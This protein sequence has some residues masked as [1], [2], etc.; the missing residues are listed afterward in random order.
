V[1]VIVCSKCGTRNEATA[2]F[3][4]GCGSFLEYTGTKVDDGAPGPAGPVVTP[5][6]AVAVPTPAPVEPPAVSPLAAVAEPPAV[7]PGVPLPSA[8]TGAPDEQPL[9][10]RPTDEVPRP[11]RPATPVTPPPV[12]VAK[13]GDIIC[14]NCHTPNEPSRHFCRACGKPLVAAAPVAKV[15]WW[16]RLFERKPAAA[17][18]AGT[19]PEGQ[20]ETRRSSGAFGA[21]LRNIVAL[22]FTVLVTFGLAG[23]IAV[24]SVHSL[25][26]TGIRDFMRNFSSPV[27]VFPT[28]A[29]G[30]Q[31]A[32][33]GP[34]L[35]QDGSHNQY[36]AG[37]TS[38]TLPKLQ[39]T[40]NKPTD[41]VLVIIT[42][43]AEDALNDFA[44][45]KE[46]VFTFSDGTVLETPLVEASL[47]DD[48][49]GRGP[50]IL[51][52]QQFST[53]ARDV[54]NVTVEVRSVYRGTRPAVAI[55]EIQFFTK[56]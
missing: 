41:I 49:S 5:P 50:K 9:Q 14:A 12:I 21:T 40:F 47:V 17:P 25:I 27:R 16:R 32:D 39:F 30:D 48:P 10:R 2:E 15:P 46:L 7:R 35:T 36:W 1:I 34:E 13:P 20:R 31:I 6:P 24:P 44:R 4:G 37:L 28:G 53:S 55:A 38:G 11:V 33:H 8:S 42:P 19:R 23:Y 45:P 18:V 54:T 26:D 51:A 52:N 29:G 56:P 22:V 3:C 43:G